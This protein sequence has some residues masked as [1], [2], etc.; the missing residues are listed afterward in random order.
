MKPL[1]LTFLL[2]SLVGCALDASHDTPRERFIQSLDSVN[3]Q[4][5]WI[6]SIASPLAAPYP[7]QDWLIYQTPS[8]TITNLGEGWMVDDRN[9]LYVPY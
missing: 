7:A 6:P 2:L 8:G 5:M 4:T 9:R 1:L 3:E